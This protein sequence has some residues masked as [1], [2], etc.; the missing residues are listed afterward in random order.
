MDISGLAIR[1]LFLFF[2][3]IVSIIVIDTLTIHRKWEGFKYFLFIFVL[4][5]L[6]YLLWFLLTKIPLFPVKKFHFFNALF[7]ENNA[8]DTIEILYVSILAL[9]VGILWTIM[10]K[11]KMVF[12]IV[13]KYGISNKIG[14][15]DIW[16]FISSAIKMEWVVIRDFERDLMF[17]GWIDSY[18]DSTDDKDEIFL[19]DVIVKKNSTEEIL[20]ETPGMYIIGARE[21]MIIEFYQDLNKKP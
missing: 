17:V 16:S 8:V 20:Y 9:F 1:L 3:G 14:D 13:H 19:R 4:G 12:S 2:P 21:R 11:Y 6:N 7:N 18:S 10:T 15:V 5:V